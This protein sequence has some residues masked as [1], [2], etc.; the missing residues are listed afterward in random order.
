M[1]AVAELGSAAHAAY[2]RAD[3]AAE[4]ARPPLQLRP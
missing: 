3:A 1:H 4:H 2:K